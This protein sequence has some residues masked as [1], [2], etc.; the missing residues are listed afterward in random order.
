V[1]VA[2]APALSPPR[3]AEGLARRYAKRIEWPGPGCHSDEPVAAGDEESLQRFSAM[4]G[5]KKPERFLAP[6]GMTPRRTSEACP[7]WTAA[8]DAG[9][10]LAAHRWT[11]AA[12]GVTI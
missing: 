7:W 2:P 11:A 6:L 1:V 8:A 3:R 5:A 10:T 9:P 4:D 12:R